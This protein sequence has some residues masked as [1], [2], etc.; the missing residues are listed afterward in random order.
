MIHVCIPLCGRGSR[1]APLNKPFV[2]VFEKTI[3]KYVTD[4]LSVRPYIIVNDRTYTPE[5]ETYG[6]IINIHKETVGAAETIAEGLKAAALLDCDS[7]SNS[8]SSGILIVDGDNY[9]CTDLVKICQ[10]RPSEN[11]V[12]SFVDTQPIPY[13]SY[14]S[15]ADTTTMRINTIREKEKL[16][17]YANTG[18]YYFAN[19]K[20]CVLY[21][22]KVLKQKQY[23]K[24]EA[25][26]SSV[27][28]SMLEDKH[29]WYAHVL[30]KG[31]YHSL[32]TPEQVAV[33]TKGAYAFLFDLDGTLVSTDD[34]YYSVWEQVLKR[35]HIYVTPEIYAKYIHSNSDVYV[36]QMLLQHA[37]I[38][39]EELSIEKDR[40]FG[41][42]IDKVKLIPGAAEIMRS[43]KQRGHK[44]AIVTN[45]NRITAELIITHFGLPF[46]TLIIGG[47][48]S[49]PKPYADP[50]I[51]AQ[52]YFGIDNKKCIIFEDSHNGI[53]SGKGIVPHCVVGIG[54]PALLHAGA[55]MVIRDFR[56]ITID[57]LIGYKEDRTKE[58]EKFLWKSLY[59]RFP[60]L[61]TIQISPITLKG[62]FIADVYAITFEDGDSG[63]HE[64]IFKVE[65]NN[66]SDLNKIAHELELYSRENYFYESISAHIPVHVPYF[67]GLVRDDDF[68]IIGIL[69]ENLNREGFH[70]N[71]DLN[72]EPIDTTLAV[73][74]DMAKL[75]A[76]TWGKQLPDVFSD[77][78]KNND[79]VFQ[80][81]W[82]HFIGGRIDKFV[83]TW[84]KMMQQ[85]MIEL[86]KKIAADYTQIQNHLSEE[87]LCL[88]HGDVKSPN[89]FYKMDQGEEKR[90]TPYFIDWQYIVYGKGVQDL[91]FFMIESFTKDNIDAY[92][93]LFKEY[94]YAKLVEFGVKGYTRE[95]YN[96]DFEM[97]AFYFPFFVAIWFGTTPTEDLIDVNFP[98]FF[99]DRLTHF[100][101]KLQSL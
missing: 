28:H 26:I 75:H 40:L 77:I 33:Y 3:L 10:E 97:A 6:H 31:L 91:V 48:C 93:V 36:K 41:G 79:G 15:V 13:Y 83:E 74:R 4:E 55:N 84:G 23:F 82:S 42:Y 96:R 63:K 69:L 81:K 54:T 98:Y 71:L 92:F 60:T 90:V 11:R 88:V 27:I 35:F 101:G 62:G 1:F 7:S 19:A 95:Q 53:L 2:N 14:V 73:I 49:R 87:P 51:A 80:P 45:A 52:K 89:I 67:Y 56:E 61:Q 65:N 32:G 58:Y 72:K 43:I 34:A 5:L 37:D 70:L 38:T 44:V 9:Y 22:D 64:A 16:S 59:K 86:Y 25:Y 39:V 8:S 66:G 29:D 85:K 76:S 46:D 17:D 18:A 100:Y 57:T 68:K 50:Y 78:K 21:A 24:G 99:I 12:F 94:Y 47:E 20:E 30:E